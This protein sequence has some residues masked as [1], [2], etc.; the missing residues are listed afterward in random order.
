MKTSQSPCRRSSLQAPARQTKTSGKAANNKSTPDIPHADAGC[1]KHQLET[2][3]LHHNI[4]KP[5][6]FKADAQ[7]H[8]H[9]FETHIRGTTTHQ[10]EPLPMQTLDSTSDCSRHTHTHTHT[11]T[12]MASQ[13]AELGF[14]VFWSWGRSQRKTAHSTGSCSIQTGWET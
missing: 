1:R 6:M 2:H 9:P 14:L 10:N 4:S 11:P 13:H 8:K 5:A 12:P 3:K 7:F